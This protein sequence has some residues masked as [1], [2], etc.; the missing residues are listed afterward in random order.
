M[1]TCV[2]SE[3]CLYPVC[4]YVYNIFLVCNLCRYNDFKHD[5]LSACNCTPPYSAVNAI[6]ARSD[7]NSVNGTYPF[8]ALDHQLHGGIDMKV[9]VH[10][11]NTLT[12]FCLTQRSLQ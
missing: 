2:T 5:P 12:S 9:C 10:I 7:L 6:S 11:P 4:S 1:Y 3:L 8:P